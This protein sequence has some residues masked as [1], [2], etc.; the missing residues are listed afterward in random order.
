MSNPVI[1]KSGKSG[2]LGSPLH[3]ISSH[4]ATSAKRLYRAEDNKWVTRD[5]AALGFLLGIPLEA[6][7]SI[8]ENGWRMQQADDQE[9]AVIDTESS[10]IGAA[11]EVLEPPNAAAGKWWEATSRGTAVVGT[12]TGENAK[13]SQ[14]LDHPHRSNQMKEVGVMNSMVPGRRLQ[15]DDATRVQIPLTTET[16]TFHKAIA[17]ESAIRDWELSTTHG[18]RDKP[19]MLDGRMFFSASGSYPLSVFSLIRYEPR[20]E[21]ATLRRQKLEARGGGGATFV[22][23]LRDW[24][25][26]SYRQLLPRTQ[27]ENKA[28]NRFLTKEHNTEDDDDDLSTS[29]ASSDDSDEYRPGLLDDPDMVLGRHRNVM[30]GDKVVGPIVASTIQFVKP[31]LLKEEL[32]KQFRERFDGWEPSRSAR[33]FIGARVVD[34]EYK[35][36]DPADDDQSSLDK[37]SIQGSVSSAVSA[38]EGQGDKQ[39]RIP[40]SLTLSKIRALKQQALAAAVRAKLQIGT[41]ALAC[42]Y[43][44]RLCLDCR[45]DKSNRRLSF[46]AC[47]LLALKFNEPNISLRMEEVKE[48]S[49]Q[50]GAFK[51]KS[52]V[53]PNKRN[54]TMFASLLEFF[55]QQWNLN[56]K[57]LFDAEWGVFA[58]LGFKLHVSPSH[59]AFHFRRLMKILEWTPRTYLGNSMYEQWQDALADEEQ[60]RVDRARRRERRRLKKESMILNLRLELENQA[61]RTT[62]VSDNEV[63]ALDQS[64]VSGPEVRLEKGGKKS[65][66]K[67]FQRFGLKRSF[68]TENL[69]KQVVPIT[70]STTQR[71]NGRGLS[72]SPSMPILPSTK[73]ES[74]AIDVPFP[75]EA[76][77]EESAGSREDQSPLF[78]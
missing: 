52:F 53:K 42:V 50:D 29:S 78:V 36:M 21:E 8:V 7:R 40:P 61:R 35:L 57:H 71:D 9:E 30:I 11:G 17:R 14:L 20:K 51:F 62:G 45:V 10:Q 27:N 39:I 5:I 3:H 47:I 34:G 18:L 22:M 23:P 41:V 12:A 15:G 46:A 59:V 16:L 19:A 54:K 66:L 6:E 4:G 1:T 48:A 37:R 56:V 63:T 58:A 74:V 68:S 43:F 25:G 32:N 55:T 24:R 60:R 2:S 64:Q 70:R 26:I 49:T 77:M 13:D 73:Q 75:E 72:S 67:L 38:S 33:K 28:F 31:T 76:E 44:E 69:R 65:G